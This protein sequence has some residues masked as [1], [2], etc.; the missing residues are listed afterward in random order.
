MNDTD[1]LTS[2]YRCHN[3][4]DEKIL[5]VIKNV[6]R[7]LFLPKKYKNFSDTDLAIPLASGEHMLTPS[8]EG[9]IMQSM[10]FHINDNV[11]VVGTGSGYLTECISHLTNTVSSYEV[12]EKLF[13]YGKNNL[14]LHSNN[15]YKIHLNHQNI[16]E[17]LD[18]LGR[19]TKVLFTCSVDSYK[20]FIELLS[21]NSTSFFF[22]NQYK[23]PYKAGNM[24]TKTRNGYRVKENIVISQTNQIKD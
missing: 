19:Y 13:S 9:K 22:I 7:D 24:I 15:R 23:S 5:S 6:R 16:L 11:L 20:T 17:C 12:D 4:I 10:D 14:D 21:N 18:K 8:C 3:I 1:T 2:I